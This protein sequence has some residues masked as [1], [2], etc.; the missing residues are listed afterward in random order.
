MRQW[1]TMRTH[2]A[3]T[4]CLALSLGLLAGGG[5]ARADTIKPQP[6]EDAL[7]DIARQLKDARK[8]PAGRKKFSAR[9]KDVFKTS[10]R[11]FA[12]SPEAARELRHLREFAARRFA[13]PEADA[14]PA[15]DLLTSDDPGLAA[16]VGVSSFWHELQHDYD[17]AI[18]YPGGEELGADLPMSIEMEQRGW[19]AGCRF[20]KAGI[21][22]LL[23]PSGE[24]WPRTFYCEDHFPD[25]Y[26][27]RLYKSEEVVVLT[28]QQ[29]RALG[30]S[31]AEVV[32]DISP[33]AAAHDGAPR[34]APSPFERILAA[35]CGEYE[36]SRK[37]NPM[38]LSGFTYEWSTEY[39][40]DQAV[41]AVLK[42]DWKSSTELCPGAHPPGPD[43]RE[44]ARQLNDWK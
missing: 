18:S 10:E 24:A 17:R 19:Q 35:Y 1:F 34:P 15:R 3:S 31:R 22:L 23:K 6:F 28:A 4:A 29:L 5:P 26:Y 36:R 9:K 43:L 21:A 44:A 38:E 2:A 8:P 16:L 20:W 40:V 41:A 25:A 39:C 11:V 12:S 30:R 42:S 37:D 14:E 33:V 27:C 7:R 32:A 13:E